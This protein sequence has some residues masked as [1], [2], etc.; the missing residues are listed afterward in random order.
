MTRG[1]ISVEFLL[2]FGA[3]L[4][5]VMVL[6]GALIAHEK[7]AR[8]KIDDVE[9]INA[10]ESAAR[11]V[12]AMLN[13]GSDMRFDFRDENI[14]YSVEQGKF[15]IVHEGKAIEVGGVFADDDSKPI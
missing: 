3:T 14:F 1:Q 11:A 9:R 13:S 12:E 6:A 10:A 7:A 15:H 4:A 2:L 8:D 5:V